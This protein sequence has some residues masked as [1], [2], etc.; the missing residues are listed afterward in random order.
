MSLADYQAQLQ[1]VD[2]TIK[3][4]ESTL[5][6]RHRTED[7]ETEHPR[8]KDLYDERARLQRLVNQASSGG[9]RVKRIRIV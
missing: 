5:T 8:L 1:R 6:Q 2:D 4:I 9:A 7:D 3:Q